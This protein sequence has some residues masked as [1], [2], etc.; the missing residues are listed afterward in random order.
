MVL[1]LIAVATVLAYGYVNSATV[2]NTA[3]GNLLKSTQ[4][5]YIAESGLQHAMLV[6]ATEKELLDGSSQA[7]PLGPYKID[8]GEETYTF[9][10]VEDEDVPGRYHITSEATVGGVKRS[11]KLSVQYQGGSRHDIAHGMMIGGAAATLPTS[12]WVEGDVHSNGLTFWNF[13]HIDGDV[14]YSGTIWDP[15]RWITGS[16]TYKPKM[17]MPVIIPEQYKSY[18]IDGVSGTAATDYA[19]QLKSN[20][21]LLKGSG[22]ISPQNPAGVLWL[23]PNGSHTDFFI[24]DNVEF[25][26]T[27]IIEGDL[28]L[29]GDDISFTPQPGF[30]AIVCTGRLLIS[31]GAE[32]DI[33]GL[34][35]AAGG[36]AGTDGKAANSRTIINGGLIANALGYASGLQGVHQLNFDAELS[37]I[38]DLSASGEGAEGPSVTV[39][40]YK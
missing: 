19:R 27:I 4:A 8:D 36:I 23:Q 20:D 17:E 16:K 33:H 28:V 14:S 22:V 37:A 26:G 6:L 21:K 1:L 7:A 11:C 24:K 35:I 34:V 32:A 15:F 3:S 31:P 18:S 13:S 10:A 9:F 12:L 38:Y 29:D 39:L 5:L 25:H 40:E 30:P 2:K